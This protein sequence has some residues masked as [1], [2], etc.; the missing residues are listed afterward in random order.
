[1]PFIAMPFIASVISDSGQVFMPHKNSLKYKLI[2]VPI[3]FHTL[4]I[5]EALLQSAIV[6]FQALFK[7]GQDV[8]I[9][10]M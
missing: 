4:Q 9:L 10:F 8:K 7:Q 3:R 1:M 2:K 6:V 5:R